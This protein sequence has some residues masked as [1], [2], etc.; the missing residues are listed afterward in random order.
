MRKTYRGSITVYLCLCLA[1][2]IACT[3]VFLESARIRGMVSRTDRTAHSALE[4]VMADY[5]RTIMEAYDLFLLDY[6]RKTENRREVQARWKTYF[7]KES[8]EAA[9][10]FIY[11]LLFDSEWF[12]IQEPD[13]RITSVWTLLDKEGQIFANQAAQYMKYREVGNLVSRIMEQIKIMLKGKEGRDALWQEGTKNSA[14]G[15]ES[16]AWGDE[17]SII[18]S[19]VLPEGR[20]VSDEKISAEGLP[21]QIQGISSQGPGQSPVW[22]EISEEV[23]IGEYLLEHFPD[24]VDRAEQEKITCQ[25]EYILFGKLSDRSNM[26]RMADLLL[27][28][29]SGLNLISLLS[30]EEMQAAAEAAAAA[31]SAVLLNPELA[32]LIQI[33]LECIWAYREAVRDV[34]ALL[35]GEKISFLKK[36]S[37]WMESFVPFGQS[38]ETDENA[39]EIGA[40]AQQTG[41]VMSV[42]EE[43]KDIGSQA[44]EIRSVELSYQDYIRLFLL[45]LSPKVKYYRAMD[46][47]QVHM[48]MTCPVFRI[49][50]CICGMEA[51]VVVK[52][53]PKFFLFASQFF[54]PGEIKKQYEITRKVSF[55][56]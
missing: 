22:N 4:S 46:M 39:G 32:P 48:Q 50:D 31:I 53:K 49:S 41:E 55:L 7:E 51:S 36:D 11:E 18:L 52:G 2:S 40:A 14:E 17:F 35:K 45:L 56:Y 8:D 10:S 33:V 9:G 43:L 1:L 38:A 19:M 24:F 47:M 42:I 26:A 37:Q 3:G 54:F 29:R 12:S 13:C 28:V 20:E 15:A 5:N 44:G 23:L 25:L 16:T 21:S 27:A 6:G 30:S 34:A